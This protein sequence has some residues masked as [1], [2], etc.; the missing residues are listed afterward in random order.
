L[1]FNTKK[2]SFL[3][4]LFIFFEAISG[5]IPT[6]IDADEIVKNKNVII[7]TG[8]VVIKRDNQEIIADKVTYYEDKDLA[9][10]EGNV[11]IKTPNF[12]GTG[13][14][15]IWGF[16]KDEGEIYNVKGIIDGEYYFIA[17]KIYKKGDRYYFENMKISK[18]PFNQY[19]WYISG[20]KGNFKS[21]DYV[22]SYN[23]IFRFCKVPILYTPYFAYPTSRRKSGFLIP[24]ISTNTYNDY[25]IRIP[26]FYVINRTSD[27][28]VTYDYRNNQGQGV[29]LEY[30]NRY[31]KDSML[32]MNVFYFREKKE[33]EWWEGRAI[34]PI[35]NRWRIY[36]DTQ[37]KYNRLKLFFKIDIPS[38][39]YFFED[40]GA[41]ASSVLP[42]NQIYKRYIA[43]TKS[44]LF[45]IYDTEDFSTEIN[46]EYIY[47]LTKPNNEETL[48]RFPE[49]RFYLKKRPLS[50]D[51]EIYYDF[52][53]YNTYFYREKGLRGFRSDNTLFLYHFS[54]LW[55]FSNVLE[56]KPRYT[57]YLNIEDT[58]NP[59]LFDGE[60]RNR[61]LVSVEDRLRFIEYKNY[62][63]FTHSIIPQLSFYFTPKIKQDDIP[64]FD[65]EDNIHEKNE[66]YLSLFNILDFDNNNFFRWE[67]SQGYSF[68]DYYYIG[69]TLFE[70]SNWIPLKNSLYLSL[71]GYSL[72]HT[73]FFSW[74]KHRLTSSYTNV[75]IPINKN[76]RYSASHVYTAGS[77]HQ[78]RNAIT[79]KYKNFTFNGSILSNLKYGY[80]QQRRYSILYDRGCW[81]LQFVYIEDFNRTTDKRFRSYYIVLNILDTP[82]SIFSVSNQQ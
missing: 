48:Q 68:N 11:K 63:N 30:R 12:E 15:G 50:K 42:Y 36:G 53:S 14:A 72:D 45:G 49:V 55:K 2:Y 24:M 29:N 62:S 82:L 61:F 10:F 23:T 43:Y 52:L 56:V 41:A 28:T 59:E 37:F 58:Q 31:L 76:L 19:D 33:G 18:C 7:A 38:D 17:K 64:Q 81:N 71:N 57:Q 21:N 78:L 6:Y 74:D 67:I 47:D 39:P 16:K 20:K 32:N 80:T 77:N 66:M 5:E 75:G 27:L 22:Y 13:N 65:K 1:K 9:K 8:N 34:S 70:N 46:F 73:L 54:N 35:Q 69:D 44:Q 25:I 60:S 79:A 51:L 40:Y 26:Y 3:L 4:S